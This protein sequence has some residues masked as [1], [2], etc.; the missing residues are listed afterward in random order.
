M[1]FPKK[2]SFLPCS[3]PFKLVAH[4][5]SARPESRS[6]ETMSDALWTINPTILRLA[7]KFACEQCS[8]KSVKP[9]DRT[10]GSR[11]DPSAAAIH[12]GKNTTS[13]Q[14]ETISTVAQRRTCVSTRFSKSA[15]AP[16]MVRLEVTECGR[17]FVVVDEAQLHAFEK[18]RQAQSQGA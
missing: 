9:R 15:T 12:S 4:Q 5:S 16:P 18:R 8:P 3:T 2:E 17:A 13:Q 7:S 14:K 6:P 11:R 1:G 10:N